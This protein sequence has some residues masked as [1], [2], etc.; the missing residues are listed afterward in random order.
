[1]KLKTKCFT[2]SSVIKCLK[3]LRSFYIYFL[4]MYLAG[5]QDRSSLFDSLE[6]LS[7][8]GVQLLHCTNR[9]T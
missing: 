9:S 1:M 4:R 3:I 8:F 6:S 2:Y 5:K 7:V